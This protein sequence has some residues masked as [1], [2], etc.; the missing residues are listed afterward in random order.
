VPVPAVQVLTGS[1]KAS[2]AHVVPVVPLEQDAQRA[3]RWPVV[4]LPVKQLTVSPY[5]SASTAVP[6]SEI[7]IELI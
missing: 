3:D 4:A 7:G 5:D 6:L 1:T 2:E